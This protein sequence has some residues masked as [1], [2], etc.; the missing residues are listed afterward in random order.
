MRN[1]EWHERNR[2][3]NQLWYFT[4]YS[5]ERARATFED[6]PPQMFHDFIN[7]QRR[8]RLMEIHNIMENTIDDD[9]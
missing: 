6:R 8:P 1:R 9:V 4:R 5:V 3:A 2:Y 7:D